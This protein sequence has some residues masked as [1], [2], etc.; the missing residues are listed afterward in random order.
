L[1]TKPSSATFNPTSRA[2][3]GIRGARS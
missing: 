2:K 1:G 3:A